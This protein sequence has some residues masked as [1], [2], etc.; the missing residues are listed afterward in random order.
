M[1]STVYELVK[2][3]TIQEITKERELKDG[4]VAISPDLGSICHADLRYF[5]GSRRPEALAKKLPMALIHE[6]IGKVIESRS[7]K[8][9]PGDRV[10]IVPNLPARVLGSPVEE[11]ETDQYSKN[12][13][14]MGSGYDG[15]AQS[16]VV[17]PSEC[18]VKIPDSVP[19]QLA[20]L[21]EMS[22]I[23]VSAVRNIQD[24][25]SKDNVQVAIFGDG[26]V[27]FLTA[28]YIS[29]QYH[30]G[31]DQLT[32]FG[33]DENKLE[34]FNFANVEN[35]LTYNFNQ[36]KKHYNIV[37]E[38]TGGKFSESAINQSIQVVK[39]LG[40]IILMGV[41]EQKV[42]MNTRDILEKGLTIHGSSR[43]ITEDFEKV[44]HL[45]ES[46]KEYR[47]ALE[48]IVPEST[49]SIKNESDFYNVM[50]YAA[51]TPHWKK[52]VMQYQ[53]N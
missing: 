28:A 5:T 4:W 12:G 23:S 33:A 41:S 13:K 17:H 24:D 47:T 8:F 51:D 36:S 29:N 22:S 37:I 21:S 42:P 2:P 48:K 34:N 14:F 30:L 1:K 53:W 9:E 26:P 15:I 18:I 32:V 27:G 25:L 11:N 49:V 35:V 46:S 52:I 10:A 7:D 45:L 39:T 16:I 6:G 31:A 38:C 3:Y 20:V 40:K 43:S 50:K 44:L 19:D